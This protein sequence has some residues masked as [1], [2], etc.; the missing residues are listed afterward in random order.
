MFNKKKALK[1]SFVCG[2]CGNSID[3]NSEPNKEIKKRENKPICAVCRATKFS[4]ISNLIKAD[5]I[6]YETD[7]NELEKISRAKAMETV[8]EVAYASQQR[9]KA[10]ELAQKDKI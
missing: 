2:F 4:D 1:K 3:V 10:I 5:K 9:A 8:K 6:K 7:K